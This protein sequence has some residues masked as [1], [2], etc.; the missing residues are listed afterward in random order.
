MHQVSRVIDYKFVLSSG[1]GTNL[2]C[3]HPKWPMLCSTAKVTTA[4]LSFTARSVIILLCI[5]MVGGIGATAFDISQKA[6]DLTGQQGLGELFV[7][8]RF[9]VLAPKLDLFRLQNGKLVFQ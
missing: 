2:A 9:A 6:L 7:G 4:L 1:R 5:R 8:Y 3:A